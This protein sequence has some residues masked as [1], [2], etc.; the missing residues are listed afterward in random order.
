MSEVNIPFPK[1]REEAYYGPLGVITKKPEPFVECSSAP[2]LMQLIAGIGNMFGKVHYAHVGTSGIQHT[3]IYVAIVGDSSS[4]KKGALESA[5]WILSQIDK[6]WV[7]NCFRPNSIASGQG[8]LWHL[9]ETN[10]KDKGVTDKRTVFVEEEF[11]KVFKLATI[12]GNTITET[13]KTLYD[14]P[15]VHHHSTRKDAFTITHAHVSLIVHITDFELKLITPGV[16]LINGYINRFHWALNELVQY[17]PNPPIP[18]PQIFE[19]EV[20]QLKKATGM[21]TKNKAFQLI[22]N[23]QPESFLMQR[24]SEA[25]K[26]WEGMYEELRKPGTGHPVIQAL[27]GRGAANTLR[28]SMIY[29]LCDG[30]STIK[31][32]HVKAAKAVWEYSVQGVKYMW[33]SSTLRRKE[34]TA[35]EA[36]AASG[37]KGISTT[38]LYHVFAK[39]ITKEELDT[40]LAGLLERSFIQREEHKK[41][42]AV[43]QEVRY[44]SNNEHEYQAS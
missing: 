35:L 1:L 7:T 5:K 29:A 30:S 34:V 38:E 41:E 25:D 44:Y 27:L 2:I 3:N 14:S 24:T 17:L 20:D 32:V 21:L 18:D 22:E 37:E 36:I 39:N 11:G 26:L 28:T 23:L 8:M 15:D 31:T 40:V 33:E 12:K 9:R 13:I 4:G 19:K 42:G 16:D 10:N 6:H 43:K